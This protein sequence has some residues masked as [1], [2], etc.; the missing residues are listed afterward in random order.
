MRISL[1]KIRQIILEALHDTV[2][3]AASPED[4]MGEIAQDLPEV[5]RGALPDVGFPVRRAGAIIRP[6]D[7]VRVFAA[8][9]PVMR[10]GNS[11]IFGLSLGD[12]FDPE[13]V[14]GPEDIARLVDAIEDWLSPRGWTLW[15]H[16]VESGGSRFRAEIL[17]AEGREAS[18]PS[19][20]YHV[21]DAASAALIRASGLVP[22]RSKGGERRYAPRVH[23]FTT[24]E[25]AAEQ[26]EHNAAA[27]RGDSWYAKLTGGPDVVV[28][29]V[30]GDRL[31]PDVSLRLDPEFGSEDAG[32]VYTSSRIPASA[33][34]S[35]YPASEL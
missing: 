34:G 22:G 24:R 15:M 25:A 32:A 2:A 11:I 9:P 35:I 29:E 28:V 18:I 21:T 31:P 20:L 19:V 6:M 26:I 12:G 27:W 30:R 16:G 8:H 17:P 5:L 13:R 1:G 7:I 14:P 10:N 33:I 23:L 4:L 3:G